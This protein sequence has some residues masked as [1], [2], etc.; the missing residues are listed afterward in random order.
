[1][2]NFRKLW[3]VIM[4]FI[5]NPFSKGYVTLKLWEWFVVPVFKVPTLTIVEALGII[6]LVRSLQKSKDLKTEKKIN[7]KRLETEMDKSL[8]RSLVILAIGCALSF[9]M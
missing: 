6:L 5:L 4:T 7:W 2:G 8:N 1:M 3:V 9:L